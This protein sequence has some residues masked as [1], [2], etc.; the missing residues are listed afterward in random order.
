MN[1]RYYKYTPDC[2][3]AGIGTTAENWDCLGHVYGWDAPLAAWWTPMVF[4]GFKED[5]ERQGDFPSLHDYPALPVFSQRAWDVLWPL[6]DCRWE[7][8]PIVHPSGKPFYIVH[9]MEVI[10]CVDLERSKVELYRS[11]DVAEIERYCLKAEMLVGKHVFK[12]PI[13]SGGELLLDDVFRE[14]VEKNGLTGLE[15]RPLPMVR[16]ARP[17]KRDNVKEQ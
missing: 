3:I 10:D 2:T 8:L 15:F 1:M 16:A 14:A 6:I 13:A 4:H 17:Q 12:T 7:A 11:G 5:P 9:V